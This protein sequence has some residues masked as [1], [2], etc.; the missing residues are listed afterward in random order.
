M[1]SQNVVFN[2]GHCPSFK[3]KITYPDEN[4]IPLKYILLC[5]EIILYK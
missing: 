1:T 3:F 5:Y 4:L 2:T